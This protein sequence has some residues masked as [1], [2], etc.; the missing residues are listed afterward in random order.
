MFPRLLK[1]LASKKKKKKRQS[2]GKRKGDSQFSISTEANASRNSSSSQVLRP[3]W[4]RCKIGEAIETGKR[5]QQKDDYPASN[6]LGRVDRQRSMS[7]TD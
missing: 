3:W 7:S 6:P 2:S 1:M 4:D 5:K